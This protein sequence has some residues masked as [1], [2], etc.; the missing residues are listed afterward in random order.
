MTDLLFIQSHAP[1]GSIKG[2][3]VL[4][5]CLM[6]S[7]FAQCTLVFLADGV[8]QLRPQKTEALGVKDY[9]VSYGA[10]RDYGVEQVYCLRT[11]LEQRQLNPEDFV[12]PVEVIDEPAFQQLI[13]EAK[14]VLT[15]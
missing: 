3:E 9:S 14:Q 15:F 5:A 12:V 1:H 6:G 13:A 8:Y 10:L 11:D 4:D 7:A 2:Q